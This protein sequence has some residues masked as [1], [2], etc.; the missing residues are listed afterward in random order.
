MKHLLVTLAIL[1]GTV[2]YGQHEYHIYKV[3]TGPYNNYTNQYD[4]REKEVNIR[5]V[6]DNSVVRIY[7]DARSVYIVRNHQEVKNDQ[8]GMISKW[9][10][11]DERNRNVGIYMAMN[12]QTGEQSLAVVYSDFMFQ[13]FFVDNE[14]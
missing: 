6:F 12:R 11:V 8:Q 10:A 3:L 4:T 2:A 1:L 7:D 14:R 9:D 5:M 13:Y